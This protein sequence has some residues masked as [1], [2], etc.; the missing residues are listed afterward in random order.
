[1][2]DFPDTM[3]AIPT[4]ASFCAS[5]QTRFPPPPDWLIDDPVTVS[6]DSQIEDFVSFLRTGITLAIRSAFDGNTVL[7]TTGQALSCDDLVK[8]LIFWTR[9]AIHGLECVDQDDVGDVG[10][11]TD[12]LGMVLGILVAVDEKRGRPSDHDDDGTWTI[13]DA[14]RRQF[15]V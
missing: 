2:L 8:S 3:P 13:L 9:I 4:L 5:A 6:S 12:E 7:S 1:M 11:L 15:E 14:L 10:D